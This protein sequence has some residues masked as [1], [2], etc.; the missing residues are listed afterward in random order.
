MLVKVEYYYTTKTTKNRR[1]SQ[2]LRLQ[3]KFHCSSVVLYTINERDCTNT[4][5]VGAGV[6][7]SPAKEAQINNRVGRILYFCVIIIHLTRYYVKSRLAGT[8]G[9]RPLHLFKLTS[10]LIYSYILTPYFS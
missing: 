4:P 5:I 6:L 9:G 2:F 7:D 10:M 3:L 1:Q 8:S